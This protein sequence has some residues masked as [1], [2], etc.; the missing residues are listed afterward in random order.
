MRKSARVLVDLPDPL[1]VKA[2]TLAKLEGR[3]RS[4]L[5]REALREY[6]ALNGSMGL[7]VG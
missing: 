1:L 2:D 7:L 6:M 4:E 3:S 5:I